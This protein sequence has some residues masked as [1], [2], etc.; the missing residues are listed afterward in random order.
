MTRIASF[1]PRTTGKSGSSAASDDRAEKTS[2]GASK[3]ARDCSG[4]HA[5]GGGKDPEGAASSIGSAA[6]GEADP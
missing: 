6:G 4:V 5:V 1:G 2:F 3:L